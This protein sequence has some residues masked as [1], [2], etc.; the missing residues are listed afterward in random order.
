M[1]HLYKLR[2]TLLNTLRPM[3]NGLDFADDIFK[4][5]FLNE[6]VWI[7][8]KVSLKFVPTVRINNITKLVQI[9]AW[10]RLGDKPLSEPM[11]VSLP[12]HICFT[13]P[14][15]VNNSI[16]Q[17]TLVVITGTNILVHCHAVESLQ[18]IWNPTDEIYSISIGLLVENGS[19][20]FD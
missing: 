20:H 9:M 13:R 10:H 12:T 4:Y 19:P 7:P 1:L 11:M 2:N 8:I 17:V 6:N 16:G 3:Q 5:I 15:R 18:P 14:Q